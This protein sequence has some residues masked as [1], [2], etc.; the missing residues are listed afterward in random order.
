M[1]TKP[2]SR[3]FFQEQGRKGAKR[4]TRADRVKGGRARALS[5]SPAQRSRIAKEAARTRWAN[6]K[7]NGAK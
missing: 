2:F 4:L 7:G 1:A 6:A 5:M 3:E